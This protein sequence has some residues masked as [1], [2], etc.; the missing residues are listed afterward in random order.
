MDKRQS[1]SDWGQIW[2]VGSNPEG[3]KPAYPPRQILFDGSLLLDPTA[4]VRSGRPIVSET[5]GK[6]THSEFIRNGTPQIQY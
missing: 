6:E 2:V 5:L 4:A 3:Q 1:Y